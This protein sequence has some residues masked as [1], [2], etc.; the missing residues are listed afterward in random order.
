MLSRIAFLTTR[1]TIVLAE[2]TLIKFSSSQSHSLQMSIFED[3]GSLCKSSLNQFFEVTAVASVLAIRSHAIIGGQAHSVSKIMTYKKQWLK[4]FYLEPLQRNSGRLARIAAQFNTKHC[5]HCKGERGPCACSDCPREAHSQ[6][7]PETLTSLLEKLLLQDRNTDSDH[8]DHCHGQ[9][10]KCTC[11]QGCPKGQSKCIV[12]HKTVVCDSCKCS[13]IIR[14]RYKCS[15]CPNYDLCTSCYRGN[16][17]DLTHAFTV[18]ERP[19]VTPVRLEPRKKLEP[20]PP[21]PPPAPTPKKTAS[22]RKMASI[23]EMSASSMKEYLR[24]NQVS[25]SGIFEKGRLRR[26]VWET[27]VDSMSANELTSFMGV[28]NIS[29][30]DCA[31]VAARRIKAKGAFKEVKIPTNTIRAFKRDQ[32]VKLAGLK[33]ADMNGMTATVVSD[34]CGAERVEIQIHASS[35]KFAVK[36]ENLILE[37]DILD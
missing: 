24:E 2:K 17:H 22:Y 37:A 34:S 13:P 11:E 19:G 33:R 30:N 6:C 3:D 15:K 1:I 31:S 7:V 8:C 28:H 23:I 10:G 27:Q 26:L 35:R 20:T 36:A 14:A 25:Y 12:H 21:P 16:C 5:S 9:D 29:L 32:R 18:I 4:T